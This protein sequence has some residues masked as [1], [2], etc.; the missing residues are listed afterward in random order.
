[1]SV[2]KAA[3]EKRWE[4]IDIARVFSALVEARHFGKREQRAQTAAGR[5]HNCIRKP[6]SKGLVDGYKYWPKEMNRV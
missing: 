3:I 5:W 6:Y 1:M 2:N 4:T